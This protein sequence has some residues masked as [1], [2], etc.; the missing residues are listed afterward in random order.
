MKRILKVEWGKPMDGP[1]VHCLLPW[2]IGW[3][4]GSTC[5]LKSRAKFGTILGSNGSL[6]VLIVSSPESSQKFVQNPQG[7]CMDS[8]LIEQ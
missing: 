1:T 4:V 7:D 2:P 6:E 8:G 3:V 5:L